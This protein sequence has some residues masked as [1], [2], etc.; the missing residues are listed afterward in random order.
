MPTYFVTGFTLKSS[1]GSSKNFLKLHWYISNKLKLE[2]FKTPNECE[3]YS[4]FTAVGS[5]KDHLKVLFNT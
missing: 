4:I 1:C 3:R 2:A 5:M